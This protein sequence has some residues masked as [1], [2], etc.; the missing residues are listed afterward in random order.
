MLNV[1][2][3]MLNEEPESDST[4]SPIQ[5]S[6]SNIQHSSSPNWR[7]LYAIVLAELAVT[8]LI[9]YAFTKLFE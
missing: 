5:H 3:S 4:P 2:C 8:I 7:R 1:E 9:F 6:T